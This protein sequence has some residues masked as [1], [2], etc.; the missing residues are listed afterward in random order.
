MHSEKLLDESEARSN[1][2]ELSFLKSRR[3][4]GKDRFGPAGSGV[5]K[6][7]DTN[8]FLSVNFT[9]FI[10]TL[11]NAVFDAHITNGHVC[12]LTKIVNI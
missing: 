7:V 5:T 10:F 9:T 2:P 11:T 3:Q 1:K 12:T 4:R 6:E 8:N